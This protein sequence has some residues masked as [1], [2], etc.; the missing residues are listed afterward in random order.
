MQSDTPRRFVTPVVNGLRDIASTE[1]N[2][3][4]HSTILNKIIP[5]SLSLATSQNINKILSYLPSNILSLKSKLIPNHQC[6]YTYNQGM[7]HCFRSIIKSDGYSGLYKGVVPSVVRAIPSYAASF[8]G[9]EAT[10]LLADKI[11]ESYN[12][13]EKHQN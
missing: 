13:I 10:L 4:K 5:P 11:K 1:I 3:V 6:Q 9:Y 7:I 12:K 2:M 8:W